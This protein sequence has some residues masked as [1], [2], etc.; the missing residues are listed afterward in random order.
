MN[1][2]APIRAPPIFRDFDGFSLGAI[3]ARITAWRGSKFEDWR[4]HGGGSSGP[5]TPDTTEFPSRPRRW[6]RRSSPRPAS[7]ASHKRLSTVFCIGRR[8][9]LR[10]RQLRIEPHIRMV[11]AAAAQQDHVGVQLPNEL[12]DRTRKIRPR[13]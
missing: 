8:T 9:Y 1:R 3:V 7:A 2:L 13:N 6:P 4:M 12:T 11:V 10:P 5:A